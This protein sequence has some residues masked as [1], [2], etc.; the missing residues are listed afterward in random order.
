MASAP[1]S[2]FMC[3]WAIYIFPGSVYI[4][5]P[6]EQADP[7]WV[8]IIHSQTHECGN[9]D[10]GPDGEY[11]FQIFGILSL[12]CV[13][14]RLPGKVIRKYCRLGCPCPCKIN[15]R[16]LS[17]WPHYH[18]AEY[19]QTAGP[20]KPLMCGAQVRFLRRNAGTA[21]WFLYWL[22]PEK[23]KSTHK[24]KFSVFIFFWKLHQLWTSAKG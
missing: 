22:R 4:F 11:L 21:G 2:T 12:Q 18:T 16:A 19:G 20:L 9:W 5:P 13:T 10:W 7:P 14:V 3:L 1:N 8:Y 6:A 24:T 15:P 23:H 17:L